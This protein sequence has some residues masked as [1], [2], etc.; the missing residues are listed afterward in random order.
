MADL[1]TLLPDADVVWEGDNVIELPN[2][3][4]GPLA[5]LLAA[6]GAQ[7]SACEFA[8]EAAMRHE[9]RVAATEWPS[10]R[11][12][13]RRVSAACAASLV[14]GM[15]L[16]TTGLAAATDL[17]LPTTHLVDQA[18]AQID[19]DL[20]S[21]PAPVT[22]T[23]LRP[24]VAPVGHHRVVHGAT[25]VHALQQVPAVS[26]GACPSG[27][28]AVGSAATT[29]L[30]APSSVSTASGSAASS[31]GTVTAVHAV[32]R[33]GTTAGRGGN[34]GGGGGGSSRGGNHGTGGGGGSSRG[35]NHGTGGGGGS[36]RGGNHGTGGGGGSSRGGN[37]GT[38]GGGGSG[39]GGNHGTGGG[40]GSGR[41]GNHGTGGH[42]PGG[43]SS[44]TAGVV[45]QLAQVT[46][47][48]PGSAAA[49][50]CGGSGHHRS[51]PPTPTGQSG[52]TAEGGN[53]TGTGT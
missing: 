13:P 45:V 46:S 8:G 7:G 3:V 37:H 48:D 26:T 35:G 24:G 20:A 36:S 9:F 44:T 28:T 31:A 19:H 4:S 23:G 17:P 30:T 52:Q 39:R 22:Q 53:G 38:G 10:F 41:G 40:G 47:G 50:K 18:I 34:H 1:S 14:A 11:R 15:I 29:C 2:L 25:T 5:E 49:K 33:S 32:H 16:A 12:H 21:P 43:A 27:T 6:A 51:R 42:C